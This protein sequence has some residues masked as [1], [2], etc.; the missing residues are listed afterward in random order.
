MPTRRPTRRPTRWL[1]AALILLAGCRSF[2]DDTYSGAAATFSYMRGQVSR[3]YPCTVAD[4]RTAV[5]AALLNQGLAVERANGGPRSALNESRTPD[6][7]PTT[8]DIDA[9][10]S[11]PADLP[12]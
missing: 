8:L 10:A 6:G 7:D 5:R 11:D 2:V 9:V 12:A 4:A 1:T 3:S